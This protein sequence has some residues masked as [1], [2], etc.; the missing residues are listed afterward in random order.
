M[1]SQSRS[2]KLEIILH[3]RRVQATPD[4]HC[5]VSSDSDL[6]SIQLRDIDN[7]I[8]NIDHCLHRVVL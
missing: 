1:I 5:L 7:D 4:T 3:D 6:M 2:V 8:D